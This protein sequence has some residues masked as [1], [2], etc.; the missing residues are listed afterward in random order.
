MSYRPERRTGLVVPVS[1]QTAIVMLALLPD[2]AMIWRRT[3]QL[4]E[5]VREELLRTLDT[6]RA[7]ARM[8]R[9]ARAEDGTAETSPSPGPALSEV[10]SSPAGS[11]RAGEDSVSAGEAAEMLGV[12]PRRIRQLLKLGLLTGHKLG[13]VWSV[14]R[15]SVEQH[16]AMRRA[17]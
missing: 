12:S 6:M 15:A 10:G 5:P 13:H 3:T 9:E 16:L 4:P 11:F 7:A 17:A 8:H 2:E 1:Q 14:Q